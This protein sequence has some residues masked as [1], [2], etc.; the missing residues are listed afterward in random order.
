MRVF[1]FPGRRLVGAMRSYFGGVT[2]VAWSPDGRFVV[3]GSQDDLVAV[4]SF[5][6]RCLIG[7]GRGH[8]SFVCSVAFDPYTSSASCRDPPPVQSQCNGQLNGSA[9]SGDTEGQPSTCTDA[10]SSAE[11][12]P[13]K[14]T[15]SASTPEIREL[16]SDTSYRFGSVGHDSDMILWDLGGDILF[17]RQTGVPYSRS[18]TDLPSTAAPNMRGVATA[19]QTSAS[20]GSTATSHARPSSSD[21]SA[22]D[23]VATGDDLANKA[24]QNHVAAESNS[25]SVS[26]TS[27]VASVSRSHGMSHRKK[28]GS[29]FRHGK[30]KSISNS[31]C[32]SAGSGE[33]GTKKGKKAAATAEPKPPPEVVELPPVLGMGE[34]PLIPCLVNKKVSHERLTDIV[35]R[36]DCIVTAAQDGVIKCWARPITVSQILPIEA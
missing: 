20:S 22:T 3:A 1:D 29:I 9:T 10:Q 26:E 5:D 8:S 19:G 33:D 12:L 14:T 31:G 23:S 28:V 30:N 25:S 21:L 16:S 34:V 6:Q 11:T 2:C 17:R 35:F 7:R 32:G 4:W 36:E 24:S 18:S 27:S 15:A 13:V